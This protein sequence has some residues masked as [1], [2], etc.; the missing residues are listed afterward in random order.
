[1]SDLYDDALVAAYVHD[2]ML[3]SFW[4]RM[5]SMPAYEPLHARGDEAVPAIL[6]ALERGDGG[7]NLVGMLHEITGE[8]PDHEAVVVEDGWAKWTVQ[9]AVD[10]WV[11]WGKE[12]GLLGSPDGSQTA[13]EQG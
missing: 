4:H 11:A 3:C 2:T 1:M 8:S 12:T 9:D 5:R 10:A 6:R 13:Q 7:M